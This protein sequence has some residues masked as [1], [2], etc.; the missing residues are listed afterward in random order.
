MS[1]DKKCS[2][3]IRGVR[4]K[5]LGVLLP[6]ERGVD[7]G[8]MLANPTELQ[9]DLKRLLSARR[10]CSSGIHRE[11]S[12]FLP[13]QTEVG[14]MASNLVIEIA[15]ENISR[16]LRDI[17]QEAIAKIF[18]DLDPDSGA[19]KEVHIES[20]ALARLAAAASW[21]SPSEG[22]VGR[23][24][25]IRG[26]RT[27]FSA[28]AL[29]LPT[30]IADEE[31]GDALELINRLSREGRPL[32][33]IYLETVTTVFWVSIDAIRVFSGALLGRKRV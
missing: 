20:R 28:L 7:I 9:K 11:V 25:A 23:L 17:D 12:L 26:A 6:S 16:V 3:G 1:R 19:E 30:R 32:W 21:S 2:S 29:I 18:S 27:V 22:N 24:R 10:F 5:A 15:T 8:T 13:V 31:I 4:R 33:Q 14:E